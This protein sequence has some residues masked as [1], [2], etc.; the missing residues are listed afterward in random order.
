MK[1]LMLCFC[2]VVCAVSDTAV[3][4]EENKVFYFYHSGAWGSKQVSGKQ[5]VV[6]TNIQQ[7]PNDPEK[8]KE[9]SKMWGDWVN[10]TCKNESGCTSNINVY[11]TA[12][13]AEKQLEG[14]KQRYRD[15]A[16]YSLTQVEFK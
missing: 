13:D 7:M 8:I 16:K 1:L 15:E 10:K 14:L 6:Y 3:A 2:L 12:A 9:M 5:Y 4:T 11:P